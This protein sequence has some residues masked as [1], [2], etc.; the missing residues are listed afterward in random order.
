M[1]NAIF[2]VTSTMLHLVQVKGLFG[3]IANEYP[4][5]HLKNI[6][7]VSGPF[8]FKNISQES[9]HLSLFPFSLTREV[10]AWLGELPEYS[11]TSWDKLSEAF[12]KRFFPS[13][14]LLQLRMLQLQ[15]D[16]QN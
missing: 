2:H 1:G 4:Q 11:I 5:D 7:D 10:T 13:L 3:G 15:D 8:T 9:F 14:K 16:I 12:L 6:I